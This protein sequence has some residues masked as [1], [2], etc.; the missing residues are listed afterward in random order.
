[1]K[2]DVMCNFDWTA[3]VEFVN[4][5]GTRWWRDRE[6]TEYA[7]QPNKQ[8]KRLNHVACW[9]VETQDGRRTRLLLQRRGL[10]LA[11]SLDVNALMDEMDILKFYK[12]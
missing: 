8:G 3:P 5:K 7:R 11:Q 9:F 1:M 4:E 10:V 2:A 12:A 6:L